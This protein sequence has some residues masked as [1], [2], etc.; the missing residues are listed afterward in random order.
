MAG[1]ASSGVGVDA[2][3]LGDRSLMRLERFVVLKPRAANDAL[4][5]ASVDPNGIAVGGAFTLAYTG[6]LRYARR[7]TMTINDDDAG[8]GLSVTAIVTG[9]RFGVSIVEEL[10]ATSTDTNDL[11]KT[12]VKY[13]DEVTSVV[14]K[15][16]T[17]DAGDDVTF[18]ISGA[19]FGLPYPIDK[20]A[21]VLMIAR[22]NAGTEGQIAVSASSVNVDEA[23]IIGLTLAAADDYEVE[24]LRSRFNDGF[25][26]KGVF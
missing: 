22:N 11:V 12:T 16:K 6:K 17:A 2:S 21:D 7:I 18:G 20:V 14:L 13:F 24:F 25:G 10:T 1:M 8:G 9:H 4:L 23:A 19:G 5:V 3:A 15:A 26:T